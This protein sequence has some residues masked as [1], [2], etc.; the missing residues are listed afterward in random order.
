[1]LKPLTAAL[2]LTSLPALAQTFSGPN[3]SICGT[4]FDE[5]GKPASLVRVTADTLD[6]TGA[7]QPFATTDKEGHFCILNLSI[8]TYLLSADDAERGYPDT[9][10]AFYAPHLPRK[11]IHVISEDKG[12][13][14]QADLHIPYKAA[15]IRIKLTDASTGKPIEDM[16]VNVVALARPKCSKYRGMS[17]AA[18]LLIPPNEDVRLTISAPGHSKWP[19]DGTPGKVVHLASG[20]TQQFAIALR[21]EGH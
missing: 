10:E 13:P 9:F 6:P 2:L 19:D 16:L 3:G 8:G 20:A 15:T 5:T 4:A 11:F 17:P 12:K 21:P 14:T 1:M 7:L 18:P